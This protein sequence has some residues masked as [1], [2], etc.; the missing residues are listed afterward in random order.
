LQIEHESYVH[1]EKITHSIK[2]FTANEANKI[3][4]IDGQFWAHESF[5]HYCRSNAHILKFVNYTLSNPV[6]AGLVQHWQD[7]KWSYCKK[8]LKFQ[9]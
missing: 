7:W 3:L 2:S 1:L 6:K 9:A 5:D 8:S 4:D